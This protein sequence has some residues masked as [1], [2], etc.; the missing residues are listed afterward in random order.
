MQRKDGNFSP[1]FA[2][3]YRHSII[4]VVLCWNISYV[5][6]MAW[7]NND[8]TSS[9]TMEIRSNTFAPI[10]QADA[11]FL[12]KIYGPKCGHDNTP[13]KCMLVSLNKNRTT[14]R[15]FPAFYARGDVF[16]FLHWLMKLS[17]FY[18]SV[19]SL[20]FWQ[21]VCASHAQ[22]LHKTRLLSNS[23]TPQRFQ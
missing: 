2:S 20:V 15:E 17:I 4:L 3:N 6:L 19:A 10:F 7:R 5:I 14:F 16:R 23:F 21:K 13:S 22:Y 12:N 11:V 8:G 9:Y 18:T 1:F